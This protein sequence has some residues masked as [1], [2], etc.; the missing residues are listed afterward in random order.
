[1]TEFLLC[2]CVVG[3]E[4]TFGDERMDPMQNDKFSFTF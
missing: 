3:S 1:M 4:E 2:V